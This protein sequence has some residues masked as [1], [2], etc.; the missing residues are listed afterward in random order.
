MKANVY[1]KN[2]LV[3]LFSLCGLSSV[4]CA[5]PSASAPLNTVLAEKASEMDQI[6]NKKYIGRIEAIQKVDLQPRVSGNIIGIRFKEG[7]VVKEGD[8]LF[9]IEDTQYKAG[10]QEIQAKIGQID[11]KLDYARRNADRQQKLLSTNAV[12]VDTMENSKSEVYSLKA[13]KL[14]AE[15]ELIK[16]QDNLKYTKIYAPISGRI[17]RVTY[18]MGNYVTPASS[19]LATIVQVDPVYVRFPISERDYISYFGNPEELRRQASIILKMAD[20]NMY[21]GKGTFAMMDNKIS[22]GTDTINTWMSFENK[23]NLLNSGGVVTVLLQKKEEKKYPSVM[24]SAIMNDANGAYLYVLD[25]KNIVQRRDVRLGEIS[26]NRQIVTS[27]LKTGESVIID[28]THKA[29]VG[30]GVKPVYR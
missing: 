7:A 10:V 19:P 29:V 3:V 11:A 5:A 2:C 24:L 16:A 23:N 27:G 30:R 28:G 22:S 17:G 12:S 21:P 4:F 25:D 1:L 6:V 9:E 13:Q 18:T 14:A 20:G 26:G 15:A 8:L